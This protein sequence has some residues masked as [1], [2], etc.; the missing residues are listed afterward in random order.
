VID[1]GDNAKITDIFH[2]GCKDNE[3]MMGNRLGWQ[4]KIN[5]QKRLVVQIAE[6]I[7]LFDSS[8]IRLITNHQ[9]W[10]EKS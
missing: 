6:P 10:H 8:V 1:V 4:G 3:L 7:R 5:F 2:C 9:H